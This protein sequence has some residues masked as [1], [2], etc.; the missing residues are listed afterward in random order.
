MSQSS[1]QRRLQPKTWPS[2]NKMSWS[3]T[4][5]RSFG[6]KSLFGSSPQRTTS[7]LAVATLNRT[8]HWSKSTWTKRTFLCTLSC[9]AQLLLLLR[10]HPVSPYP[11]WHL[12]RRQLLKCAIHHAGS[13]KFSRKS[14][15]SQP[16]KWVRHHPQAC[17]FLLG[18][19]SFEESATLLRLSGSNSAS[20]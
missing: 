15:G 9:M 18:P 4:N 3:H 19:L 13:R 6:S 7:W 10:I 1:R 12:W 2:S 8:K 17:S 11:N 16:V 14:T 5:V 20:Q